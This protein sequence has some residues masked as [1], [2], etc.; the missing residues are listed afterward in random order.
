L[1]GYY[2]QGHVNGREATMRVH[3]VIVHIVIVSAVSAL[4]WGCAKQDDATPDEPGVDSVQSTSSAANG[5]QVTRPGRTAPESTPPAGAAADTSGLQKQIDEV[6]A[7]FV[8]LQQVCKAGDIDGYVAFWD[9]ETKKEIDGRDMDVAQRRQ[10][11]RES[12]LKRPETLPGIANAKIES[13]AVDTT[14]AERTEKV[15]GVEVEGTM[16]V[17][18]TDGPALLFHETADGWK[19]FTLS[20]PEYFREQ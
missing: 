15:L 12:L 1:A 8:S 5:G 10:Q 18:F 3:R 16:M 7:A 6:R 4:L 11:R 20:T 19:L 2:K 13:I 14:Q 9:D 17:V